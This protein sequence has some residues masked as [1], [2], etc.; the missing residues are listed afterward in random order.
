MRG[1]MGVE[2]L[3]ASSV[4]WA[5]REEKKPR[6]TSQDELYGGGHSGRILD[7]NWDADARYMKGPIVQFRR[8]GG[9]V[10][11]ACG[12]RVNGSDEMRGEK[13][14]NSHRS[15]QLGCLDRTASSFSSGRKCCPLLLLEFSCVQHDLE[16]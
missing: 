12:G 14:S 2:V 7:I 4:L 15:T 16:L 3:P 1:C 11:C 13:C 5:T 10:V 8:G 9:V 6:K